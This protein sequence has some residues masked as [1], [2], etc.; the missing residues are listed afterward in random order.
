[1][2]VVSINEEMLLAH[3]PCGLVEQT[4]SST[5]RL[6]DHIGILL[7]CR[8][9]KPGKELFLER[10]MIIFRRHSFFLLKWQFSAR[11]V[12]LPR[13][14]LMVFGDILSSLEKMSYLV[15]IGQS[16]T[17]SAMTKM[18]AVP[19]LR[20]LALCGILDLVVSCYGFSIGTYQ[21]FYIATLSSVIDI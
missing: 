13:G 6:H 20:T 9:Q 4:L 7:S 12:L 8:V 10:R 5:I 2:S 3:Q 16:F 19:R 14:Y 17:M 15:Y 11:T 18:Q 1:M 21:Q